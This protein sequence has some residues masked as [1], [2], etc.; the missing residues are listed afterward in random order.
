MAAASAFYGTDSVELF[1]RFEHALAKGDASTAVALV[2]DA[3]DARAEP[4]SLLCDVI[5]P[6]QCRIGER[7]Q[8]GEWSVA[9]EHIA[10]GI[11]LAA[12]EAVARRV[13]SWP[14][15]KGRIIVG[16]A[17]REWHALAAMVVATSFRAR[18]WE[19]TFLGAATP[20]ERLYS[21]LHQVEP[22]AVAISCSV[23]GGLPST[24]RSIE[25]V[26]TAGVPV[27]AGGAAFG[28]DDRRARALGATAWAPTL[29]DGLELV[30][31]LS[32]TVEPVP[33][34]P[35]DAVAEQRTLDAEHH[36]FVRRIAE[37][38]EPAGVV[39]RGDLVADNDLTLVTRDCVE[40]PL[41]ALEGALL[42]DD[43]RLVRE[44]AD[45][46]R[47]VLGARS[48]PLSVVEALRAEVFDVV[49]ELPLARSL[50]EHYWP[51]S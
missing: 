24:R 16:C 31:D 25:S 2:D 39:D 26:T 38:W 8:S 13:R 21:Y 3:L 18:G 9:Q 17:E 1:T 22:D 30:D 46:V 50:I 33:A 43:G 41:R 45:W 12:T 44:T 40:Q 23:S 28:T 4:V 48:V 37:R 7:W 27:L 35:Q 51:H 19:V 15:T 5:T 32:T 34:L 11:S 14:I 20:A 49:A 10:T 29:L 6:A 47:E 42:T 36:S